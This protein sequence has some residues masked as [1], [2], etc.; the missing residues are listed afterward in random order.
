MNWHS[1]AIS[2]DLSINNSDMRIAADGLYMAA[3]Y[4]NG[5]KEKDESFLSVDRESIKNKQY[6]NDASV[7]IAL[8]IKDAKLK[9]KDRDK[10]LIRLARCYGFSASNVEGWQRAK[11]YYEQL[12]EGSK[13][14]DSRGRI[15]INVLKEKPYLLSVYVELGA[16]YFELAKLGQKFRFDNAIL[17]FG[18]VIQ[19]A[20]RG[21]EPWW[22][23]KCLTISVLFERGAGTDAKLARTILENLEKN[24]PE[25]FSGH[26]G[27]ELGIRRIK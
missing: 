25:Y 4:L 21:T 14:L 11:G 3:K 10:Y 5:L 12:V 22:I 23:S 1:G 20:P 26:G 18:N 2:R 17:V 6:F 27:Y 24:F 13:L 16:V 8:M 15:D 9:G 19:V 7:L